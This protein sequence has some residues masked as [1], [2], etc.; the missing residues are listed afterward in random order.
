M[1]YFLP[2]VLSA[3]LFLQTIGL[4]RK[5]FKLGSYI[6]RIEHEFHLGPNLGW[7]THLKSGAIKRDSVSF[8][9]NT[10]W[11]FLCLANLFAAL[12]IKKLPGY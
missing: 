6:A 3:L 7:E 11:M 9:E 1:A 8:W 5:V 10:T 12:I 4:R 2:L